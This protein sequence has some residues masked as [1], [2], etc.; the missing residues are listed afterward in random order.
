MINDFSR[1]LRF[2]PALKRPVFF[3]LPLLA[4]IILYGCASAPAGRLGLYPE[5]FSAQGYTRTDNEWVYTGN[6]LRVYVKGYGV[7]ADGVEADLG[8]KGYVLIAMGIENG[9]MKKVIYNPAMTTLMDNT[10]GYKKPLDF[11]DLYDLTSKDDTDMGG[12]L[13]GFGAKF[14]DLSATVLPGEKTEKLLAFTPFKKGVTKAKLVVKGVYIGTDIIDL[15]F[16]FVLRPE[17]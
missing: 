12:G 8:G 10:M 5:D 15:T 13:T 11:T 17:E 14:Y 1:I 4:L 3:C 2:E 9:S 16:P 6:D 7:V